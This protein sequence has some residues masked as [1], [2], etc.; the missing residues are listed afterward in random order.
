MRQFVRISI[1]MHREK[2]NVYVS[3]RY[4]GWNRPSPV[5][6]KKRRRPFL[7]FI[8]FILLTFG[9]IYGWIFLLPAFETGPSIDDT[10]E[11]INAII[12]SHPNYDIGVGLIDTKSDKAIILGDTKPFTAASTTKVLTA[13]IT[14]NAVESGKLSLEK[15]INDH[16]VSWHLQQMVNQSNNESWQALNYT[17]GEKKIEAYAKKIGLS[18]YKYKG[19]ILSAGDMAKLLSK[20]YKGQL[21]NPAHTKQILGYMQ[22]TNDDSFIP[23]IADTNEI[24]V[25]HKYGWLDNYVHD[26]AILVKNDTKWALAIYTHPND[27]TTDNNESRNIIH[28][29]TQ[30][31]V[32]ELNTKP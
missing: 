6:K 17:F 21:M 19:N 30:V 26:T 25:Y 28:S 2:N 4:E 29:I 32:D 20:L 27:G 14:M 13:A 18:S 11:S 24:T 15:E 22:H 9:L 8:T 7:I 12:D 16:T 3:H 23:A 1:E 10:E 31:V 5:H